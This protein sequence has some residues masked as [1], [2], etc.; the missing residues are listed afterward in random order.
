MHGCHFA[1]GSLEDDRD[2][3]HAED[4]SKAYRPVR[5]QLENEHRRFGDSS[6]MGRARENG[7]A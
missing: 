3:N 6:N 1:S 5:T 4:M 2:P 7:S